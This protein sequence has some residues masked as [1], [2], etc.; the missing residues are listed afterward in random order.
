[1]YIICG[2]CGEKSPFWQ[3]LERPSGEKLPDD[4]YECPKCMVAIRRVQDPPKAID[5]GDDRLMIIPGD[6]TIEQIGKV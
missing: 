3:W 1:M 4:C 6:I 5:M 2:N